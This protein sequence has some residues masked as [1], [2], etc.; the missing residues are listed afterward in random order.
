M[1][2]VSVYLHGYHWHHHHHRHP[3]HHRWSLVRFG[4][5]G[6][7]WIFRPMPNHINNYQFRHRLVSSWSRFSALANVLEPDKQ[8]MLGNMSEGSSNHNGP[9]YFWFL[10]LC[11]YQ[12]M[13]I[14]IIR[15]LLLYWPWNHPLGANEYEWVWVEYVCQVKD[16][17]ATLPE[18]ILILDGVLGRAGPGREEES[19]CEMELSK[20]AG[21]WC[22]CVRNRETIVWRR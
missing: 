18:W 13:I 17:C 9:I 5:G 20:L 7:S 12:D 2:N 21:I 3:H 15:Y 6:G 22:P 11:S 10:L 1:D 8:T 19:I 4:R 16:E 14:C